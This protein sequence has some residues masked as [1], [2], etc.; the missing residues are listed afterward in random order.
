[1]YHI[2][3][4]IFHIPSYYIFLNEFFGTSR[5]NTVYN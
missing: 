2:I 4:K 5:S 3:W 1:M